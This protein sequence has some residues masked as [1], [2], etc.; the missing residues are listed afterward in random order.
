MNT[1]IIM[2]T[3]LVDKSDM[4]KSDSYPPKNVLFASIEA[5]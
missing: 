4:L 1:I 5:L 3:M 2:I